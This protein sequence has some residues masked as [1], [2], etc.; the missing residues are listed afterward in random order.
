MTNRDKIIKKLNALRAL[1]ND[2]TITGTGEAINAINAYNKLMAKYKLTETDLEVKNSTISG[3]GVGRKEADKDFLGHI[4][5]LIS[6]YTETKVVA[7]ND[8]S[9]LNLVFVGIPVDVQHAVFM[10]DVVCVAFQRSKVAYLQTPLYHKLLNDKMA[11]KDIMHQ[12]E[13]GMTIVISDALEA[14]IKEKQTNTPS[15]SLIVI[16]NALIEAVIKTANNGAANKAVAIRPDDRSFLMGVEEGKKVKLR[17][18]VANNETL[19]LE[20]K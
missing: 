3:K 13:A 9:N 14:M 5:T 6:T 17:K 20:G 16:K 7:S 18:E 12:F 4:A 8:K 2:P 1:A 11:H 15:N 10:Y 19:L